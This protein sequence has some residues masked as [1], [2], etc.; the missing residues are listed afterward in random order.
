MSAHRAG[1]RASEATADV[2]AEHAEP[3]GRRRDGGLSDTIHAVLRLDG[4]TYVA[5]CLEIAVVTQADTA[6]EG[7][8]NLEDA[9]ARHLEGEDAR[10]LGLVDRP[11][12]SVRY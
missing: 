6:D 11:R 9:S 5:E 3:Y 12:I 4:R 2:V 8:E 7:L 1:P 10:A